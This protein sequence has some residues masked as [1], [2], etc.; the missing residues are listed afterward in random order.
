MQHPHAF[1]EPARTI[2]SVLRSGKSV[3]LSAPIGARIALL[4]SDVAAD[5]KT[6]PATKV[7]AINLSSAYETNGRFIVNSVWQQMSLALQY[8]VGVRVETPSDIG[9]FLAGYFRENCHIERLAF[10][11]TGVRNVSVQSVYAFLGELHSRQM[12]LSSA[13]KILQFIVSDYFS[14][15][16]HIKRNLSLE[17]SELIL[18]KQIETP[19]LDEKEIAD[20]LA[21]LVQNIDHGVEIENI[22][23]KLFKLTGGH[24][25]LLMIAVEHLLSFDFEVSAAFWRTELLRQFENSDVVQKLRQVLSEDREGIVD[26]AVKYK[27]GL[28]HEDTRSPRTMKL[29]TLGV[30]YLTLENRLKLCDGFV[31]KLI[32][33]VSNE[34]PLEEKS[35]GMFHTTSGFA[36]YEGGELRIGEGDIVVLHLSDLHVGNEHAFKVPRMGRPVAGDRTLLAEYIQNDLERLGV[37]GK[38]NGMLLSGDI[39]CTAEAGEFGRAAEVVAD[40]AERAGVPKNAIALVPGNH[41]IQWRPGEFSQRQGANNSVSRENF[42]RFYHDVV[43][44]SPDFPEITRLRS[45]NGSEIVD[46]VC[47]DSNHVEGP[48]TA[49]IGMID[50]SSLD[51]VTRKLATAAAPEKPEQRRRVWLMSH[52]HYIPVCDVDTAD[53]MNRKVSVMANAS[54]VLN[55]ARSIDVEVIVH[56]HQHQ[57]FLCQ[58][59]RWMGATDN[60]RFRPMLLI[61]AGS[62][63]AKR[64]YLGPIAQNQYFLLILQQNRLI[65]RSRKFGEEGLSFT[66]H[67]DFV[68]S[69]PTNCG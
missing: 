69:R 19:V 67:Q 40:I 46:V 59:S 39:T 65:V 33:A 32:E 53:A 60:G 62:A 34:K 58:L 44:H 9:I 49:G 63:G 47:L 56:G 27:N 16:F 30:L 64:E 31:G 61:G 12:E 42:D 5:L 7:I 29:R 36:A 54:R 3:L 52:H 35:L 6:I 38:V 28:L 17:E 37:S 8:E 57:P 22:A 25:S 23:K 2:K 41:D 11:F 24:Y 50:P 13:D 20:G 51:I 21:L 48:E 55:L 45:R 14:L 15:K 4:L 43:G 10:I 1:F 18:L 66:P 68:F 26:T